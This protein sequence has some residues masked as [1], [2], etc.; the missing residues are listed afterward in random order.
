MEVEYK[1][2]V[3]GSIVCQGPDRVINLVV[4][5]IRFLLCGFVDFWQIL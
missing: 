4:L 2:K 5:D 1:L 3:R